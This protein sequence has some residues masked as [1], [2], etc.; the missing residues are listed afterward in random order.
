MRRE[1]LAAADTM[2]PL[3]TVMTVA[4]LLAATATTSSEAAFATSRVSVDSDGGYTGVTVRISDDVPEDEC[5]DILQN[6][7]VRSN[8]QKK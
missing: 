2:P 3:R 4:M 1:R 7:K 8:G 5:A 6:L